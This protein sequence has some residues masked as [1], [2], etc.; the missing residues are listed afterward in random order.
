M[1]EMKE[2]KVI[3]IEYIFTDKRINMKS[4]PNT[5][6][7][8]YEDNSRGNLTINMTSKSMRVPYKHIDYKKAIQYVK[9]KISETF[10]VYIHFCNP[11]RSHTGGKNVITWASKTNAI[12][13]FGHAIGFAHAN[14]VLGGKKRSSVDPF[15]QMT[16]FS[17][18]PS[19]NAPHRNMK[20]WYLPGELLK[21][22][23]GK[24]TIGMLKNF[25]DVTSVKVLKCRDFYVSFGNKKGTN[26]IAIHTVYG[27]K[28]TFI[29]GMNKAAT[30]NTI[31]NSISNLKITITNVTKDLVSFDLV[32]N[33][34][35]IV[36]EESDDCS[37]DN[38][39]D[40]ESESDDPAG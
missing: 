16:I 8:Y 22:G 24:Y 25:N 27:V 14:S 38:I 20:G 12:H 21:C 34:Q 5:V 6:K 30:G 11:K 13:E 32:D 1:K 2:M 3:S 40:S 33:L 37:M 26:Y 19:T 9:S 15:D 17:P 31:I 29:V 35:E 18:Y 10:D 39:D 7:K 4:I 28:S 23:S 36:C